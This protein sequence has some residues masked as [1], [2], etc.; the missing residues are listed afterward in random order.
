MAAGLAVACLLAACAQLARQATVAYLAVD[1]AVSPGIKIDL[2]RSFIEKYRDRVT[3]Q[4][5]FTV[6][7]AAKAPF[8]AF[9]DG[10]FH[11][12]GRS[13]QVGFPTVA[14]IADASNEMAAVA[15][16]QQAARLHRRLEITGVW[17]LWPEHAGKTEEKQGAAQP[18][19]DTSNPSH[20]FEIHPLTR[21]GSLSLLDS[22]LPVKG[23]SPGDA[24][25]EFQLYETAPCALT[26]NPK[27]VS[28]VTTKGLY[29]DVEFLM[30]A[31]GDPPLVVRDG[32]FITAAVRDLK[33][34]LVVARRR[35]V[36]VKGTAPELAARRLQP[37]G[38]LHVW[39]IP[40]IDL[41]EIA[42]RATAAATRPAVLRQSL[43]YEIIVIGLFNDRKPAGSD[44][45]A[46]PGHPAP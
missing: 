26:V 5:D 19:L 46:A 24:R 31:S 37:G 14:E 10:D 17:R 28:I 2:Y 13:P 8:P 9:F 1:S 16:V 20:V 43:P 6:D 44:S 25:A 36:L 12:G 18:P 38:R 39:G 22:F 32:R 33:E 21:I 15:L 41:A 29:N 42:G 27:M 4:A 40:R 3:I 11:F 45:P 23:F 34:N 30:E 35:M 7:Q